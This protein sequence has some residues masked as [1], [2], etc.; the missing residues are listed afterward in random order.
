M[1][2]LW[3][4]VLIHGI[5]SVLAGGL[6]VYTWRRRWLTQG[7]HSAVLLL[8]GI[9][10]WAF[11]AGM[12]LVIPGQ[13][14][15][16]W[17]GKLSYLGVVATGPAW[18]LFIIQYCGNHRFL[19]PGVR[20]GIWI[21]PAITV[22]GAF[23]NDFHGMFWPEISPATP[24]ILRYAHGPLFYL[25][26]V[27][28]YGCLLFGTGC[29]VHH[30]VWL[31]NLYRKQ[32]WLLLAGV[33][34]PILTSIAFITG[35]SPIPE[36]DFTPMALTVTG[37]VT[38]WAI[39]RFRLLDLAP[40][41]YE[42]LFTSQADG[43]LVADNQDRL[44]DSNPAARK[45]LGISSNHIGQPIVAVLPAWPD[46]IGHADGSSS[47]GATHLIQAADG[48]QWLDVQINPLRKYHH[49]PTGHIV[50]LRNVTSLI[51]SQRALGDAQEAWERTFDAVPDLVCLLDPEFRVQ[52]MNQALQERMEPLSQEQIRNFNF[53]PGGSQ[54][55]L[56]DQD[57]LTP[58][59]AAFF[60]GELDHPLLGGTFL[61]TST[62]LRDADGRL[63]GIVQVAHDIT[64]LKAGEKQRLEMERLLQQTQKLESLGILAGGIAHD[65]NNLLQAIIGNIELSLADLPAETSTSHSLAKALQA[66]LHASDI[67]RQMLAYS[68][69]GHFVIQP[70]NLNGII[71]EMKEMLMVS[72][73]KK[74][75]LTFHPSSQPPWVKGDESQLRQV[76]MNLIINAAEA[77]GDDSG[78]IQ[79][80][81]GILELDSKNIDPVPRPGDMPEG[82]YVS[83]VIKDS[84]CGMSET[85]QKRIF[86]PFF[87][88]KFTGRGLGLA[89]V[90]GIVQ[91]HDGII[92]VSS[93][94]GTGTTFQV[95]LPAIQ[96]PVTSTGQCVADE[97]PILRTGTILLVDDEQTILDVGSKILSSMGF[98][99]L[100]AHDG[101]SGLEVFQKEH[102][103]ICCILLDITMPKMDGEEMYREIRRIDP[104]IPV[105]LSSGF[106][107][108]EISKR[109]DGIEASG[110]LQKPYR[111]KELK[112]KIHQV[113]GPN[114]NPFPPGPQ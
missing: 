85:T 36:I 23:T 88:T 11:F 105:I 13:G 16:V 112:E 22:I 34:V 93:N 106:S 78:G 62:P 80:S 104:V 76:I 24:H 49:Q 35:N 108:E 44:I 77:I 100:M 43:V 57:G 103:S 55:D 45:L 83:L 72:I 17:C 114:G 30:L 73:P 64:D 98:N 12:E 63:Y 20:I 89:A 9:A 39:Y 31:P 37:L 46:L 50:Q 58:D 101:E 7:A 95:L 102:R 70:L 3:I 27:F 69:R 47:P 2:P 81:T 32:S 25:N 4:V 66:S 91:G 79:I 59:S 107:Q 53:Y 33:V 5:T 15:K 6:A 48:K 71:E 28:T 19:K 21:I 1:V 94:I 65:F 18:F 84:G 42:V 92:Q 74:V 75:A 26:I 60:R 90:L 113:L 40:I 87:T 29:L 10:V 8:G 38:I 86:E 97:P 54:P 41:A 52:R 111:M 51:E 110:F 109:F 14:L 99:V 82:K 68:G 96:P 61:V 56:H 67:C